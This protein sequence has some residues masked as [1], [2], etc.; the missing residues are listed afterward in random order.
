MNRLGPEALLFGLLLVPCAGWAQATPPDPKR[1][2]EFVAD[3]AAGLKTLQTWYVEETGLW[4]TTG[5]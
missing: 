4:K 3:S 5:W 1:A 2:A